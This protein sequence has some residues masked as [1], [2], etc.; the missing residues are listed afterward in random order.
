MP[1]FGGPFYNL[2]LRLL[3]A[4]IGP[5]AVIHAKY[6]PVCT[7]LIAVG[8]DTIVR[9]DSVINGYKAQSN[10]IYGDSRLHDGV[11]RGRTAA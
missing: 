8:S 1:Q 7:D 4:K 6:L 2:Y 10:Y 11:R 3:G 5:G 9:K